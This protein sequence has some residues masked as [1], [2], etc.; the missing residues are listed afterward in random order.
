MMKTLKMPA[1]STPTMLIWNNLR[2]PEDSTTGNVVGKP[3]MGS[4]DPDTVT[5]GAYVS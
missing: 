5:D 3:R 1:N 4:G 2:Y